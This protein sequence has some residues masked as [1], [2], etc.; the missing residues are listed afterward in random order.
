MSP[1]GAHRAGPARRRARGPA[2][3]ADLLP[4]PGLRLARVDAVG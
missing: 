1:R 3:A 2:G 4:P